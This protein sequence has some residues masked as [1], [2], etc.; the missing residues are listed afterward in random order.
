M[1][2]YR[3]D[4]P[5]AF[6]ARFIA[7][8]QGERI[9]GA[10]ER[11][12]EPVEHSMPRP[13]DDVLRQR[14]GKQRIDLREDRRCHTPRRRALF[15]HASSRCATHLSAVLRLWRA[16]PRRARMTRCRVSV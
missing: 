6:L 11:D 9:F 5:P 12:A 14:R 13:F 10:G 1:E 4:R 2:Q 3:R 7:Q 8:C 16:A 15:R